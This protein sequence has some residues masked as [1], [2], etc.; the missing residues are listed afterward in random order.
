MDVG[1][2]ERGVRASINVTPL[3]DIVLVLLIIFMVL[4]PSMLE[5]L[6]ASVPKKSEE[7]TQPVAVDTSI[8]I[9]YSANRNLT[10]N[11]EPVTLTGFAPKLR[12]RL[13]ARR[14]KVVFFR[15]DDAAAY[16]EVV[17]V[18]DLARGAG[19]ETLALVTR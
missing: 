2:S 6:A 7:T 14:E 11:R 10:I 17:H 1:N 3:V 19:A 13:Q 18:M 9:D 5:H 15:A 8:V 4:T 16:G 12:Q